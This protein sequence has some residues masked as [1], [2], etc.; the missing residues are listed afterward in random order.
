MG[1]AKPAGKGKEEAAKKTTRAQESAEEESVVPKL[2]KITV[3]RPE[4]EPKDFVQ[5]IHLGTTTE[6]EAE[7]EDSAE[8][9]ERHPTKQ[10]WEQRA[11][12]PAPPVGGTQQRTK[13]PTPVAE[14]IEEQEED[15]VAQKEAAPEQVLLDFAR[16][17]LF[18]DLG[19][20][21]VPE[22]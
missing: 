9:L 19:S 20:E 3:R 22:P 4:P 12:E 6:E 16:E 15:M 18:P 5:K 7:Q 11:K 13:E 21:Q 1:Q 14:E 8:P 17:Q 10:G 2:I